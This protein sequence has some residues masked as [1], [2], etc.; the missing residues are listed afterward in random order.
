MKWVIG[1]VL[2]CIWVWLAWEIY[3]APLVPDDYDVDKEFEDKDK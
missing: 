3:Y 1:I 2:V